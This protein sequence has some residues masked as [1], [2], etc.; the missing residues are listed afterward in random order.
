MATLYISR[1]VFKLPEENCKILAAASSEPY[2]KLC[3]AAA[4]SVYDLEV[5]QQEE[6]ICTL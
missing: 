1:A 4:A 6:E 2:V 3:T 5:H